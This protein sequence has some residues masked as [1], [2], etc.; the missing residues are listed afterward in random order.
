LFWKKQLQDSYG[1]TCDFIFNKV[2]SKWQLTYLE[3]RACV[4]QEAKVDITEKIND[5]I[6]KEFILSWDINLMESYHLQLKQYDLLNDQNNIFIDKKTAEIIKIEAVMKTYADIEDK[7]RIKY[8]ELYFI[9]E[10]LK[11][12][13]Y[14]YKNLM[15]LNKKY[16][17]F[18]I[19]QQQWQGVQV[20]EAAEALNIN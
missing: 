16:E 2:K 20:A 6:K 1:F 19:L 17:I 15:S 9:E 8:N 10:N 5:I 14:D 3:E 4:L 12:I 13:G 11:L 7:L 18:N